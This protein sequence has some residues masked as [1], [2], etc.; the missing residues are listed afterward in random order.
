MRDRTVRNRPLNN[1]STA[2]CAEH[3]RTV[4]CHSSIRHGNGG[5]CAR[6]KL[7]LTKQLAG[8]QT[9]YVHRRIAAAGD[10]PLI[11]RP[12]EYPRARRALLKIKIRSACPIVHSP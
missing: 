10:D 11:T 12:E 6:V 1:G 9:E 8:L 2:K 3:R 4:A 5:A 7:G